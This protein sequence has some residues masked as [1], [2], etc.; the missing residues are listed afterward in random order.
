MRIGRGQ[1][2]HLEPV[3]PVGDISEGRCV[4]RGNG[5]VAHIVE[6]SFGREFHVDLRP[7]RLLDVH[8]HEALLAAGDV[9]IGA[10]DLNAVRVG[11]RYERRGNE[12]CPLRDGDVDHAQS[13]VVGDGQVAELQ[14]GRARALERDRR[15][16]HGFERVFEI[17]DH[18]PGGR[19]DVGIRAAH[20]DVARALQ[21]TAAIPGQRALEEVVA[22]VAVLQRVDV[23]QNQALVGVRDQRV[24]VDRVKR[25][26]LVVDAHQVALVLRRRHRLG[27]GQRDAGR[28]LAGDVRIL[29]ELRERRGDDALGH[30]LVGDRRHVI[31]A[32][33]AATFRNIEILAAK[34][35]A[36]C[37]AR[38]RLVVRLG[39][40]AAAFEVVGVPVRVGVAVEV[41]ADH[42]LRLLPLRDLHRLDVFFLSHPRVV[43]EQPDIAGAVQQ[44]LR[45]DGIVVVVGRHMAV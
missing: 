34:L 36:A 11:E 26:L 23:D 38:G 21:H 32:H 15:R 16:N 25:L 20:R 42:C 4:G 31:D 18:H 9:G 24:V 14:P 43:A 5:H 29:A 3:A 2:H 40:T 13:A 6:R 28:V 17:Y 19:G 8:D 7:F 35:D 10:R 45:H 30:A 39:Q 27:G 44:G 12:F 37:A 33:A 1:L 41:T 22:R